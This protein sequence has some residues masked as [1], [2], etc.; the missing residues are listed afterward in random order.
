M[1]CW[2]RLVAG[3]NCAKSRMTRAAVLI[4]AMCSVDNALGE[5]LP[6][7]NPSFE[8]TSRPL[9]VGE[10]TNGAGD[11]GVPVAT[12]FPFAG[13]GVSW[14][15]PVEVPGWRTRLLPSGNPATI[16]AGVLNPPEIGGQPFIAGHDG[17][18]VFAIQNAQVGQTL[19]VLLQ[20][21]TRY[22]LTFLGGIGRTDSNYF[23]AP[24]LIAVDS[25]STLPLEGEAGVRRLAIASGLAVPPQSHGT[26]LSYAFEYTSP[27]VL[28]ADLAGRFVGIHMWGSDG[29]PR[30]LYDQMRLDATPVP[31]PTGLA[32]I[33]VG[34]FVLRRARR[35][36]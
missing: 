1:K 32:A 16:R 11:M 10:Q 22:T 26:M 4:V 14:A 30:V 17:Q 9:V 27:A 6:I 8:M 2:Q 15:D 23:L 5:L 12:R 25:L 31:E 20:P 36:A 19:N 7:V 13:G 28:P 29:I 18:N 3:R 21:N 33:V 24:S 34:A 35:R